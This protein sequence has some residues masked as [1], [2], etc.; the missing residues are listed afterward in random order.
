MAIHP[1]PTELESDWQ[2]PDGTDVTIRPIRPEDATIEQ[3]FVKTLSAESKYLRFMH[4]LDQLTPMMLARLT[5]IDYDQEMALIAVVH[6]GTDD[7]KIIAVTRYAMNPDHHSC[8]FALTVAD[9]Y[10]HKGIGSYILKRL[11]NIARDRGIEVMEA[12]I[13]SQNFKM[14]SLVERLG[15]RKVHNPDDREV[16]HVRRH[17]L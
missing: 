3:A 8:E 9:N 16:V 7:A 5:Q 1:Y 14:L 11:T 10:Q 6:D 13:L 15:F 12:E 2:L 17:L 4:S